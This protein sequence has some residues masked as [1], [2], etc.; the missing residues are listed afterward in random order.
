MRALHPLLRLAVDEPQLMAEH[1]AAYAGLVIEEG[2][3]AL[4]RSQRRYARQAL[5]GIALVVG[6]TLVGVALML[7]AALPAASLP[8][9]WV[10]VVVPALPLVAAAILLTPG[11]VHDEPPAFARL[12]RQAAADLGLWRAMRHHGPTDPQ[13]DRPTW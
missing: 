13:G 7:W 2:G 9:P 5:G 10:L 4:E 6:G 3:Q 12:R 11:P 8:F 1:M